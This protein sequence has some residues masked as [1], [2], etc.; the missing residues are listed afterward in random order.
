[1][2]KLA[3]VIQ[4]CEGRGTVPL[5]IVT[6]TGDVLL[7]EGSTRVKVAPGEFKAVAMYE[8]I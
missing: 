6:E 1:M 3:R 5:R 8:G 2:D 7:D 4:K